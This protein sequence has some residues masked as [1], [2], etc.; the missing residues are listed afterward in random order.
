VQYISNN[1]R[2]QNS[3]Q[4]AWKHKNSM[5]NSEHN[6][7]FAATLMNILKNWTTKIPNLTH[8]D[9]HSKPTTRPPP[10]NVNNSK[11]LT[12]EPSVKLV[13]L[14]QKWLLCKS[15]QGTGPTQIQIESLG[16]VGQGPTVGGI[17]KVRD[18][19]PGSS[20]VQAPHFGNVPDKWTLS[21]C[22]YEPKCR[23]V[24]RCRWRD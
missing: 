6:G 8:L 15:P 17:P 14:M 4:N 18:P 23:Q 1:V 11:N 5:C 9:P 21:E 16:G 2:L 12:S 22:Y 20:W 24:M 10:V 3:K 19:R 13:N 7:P